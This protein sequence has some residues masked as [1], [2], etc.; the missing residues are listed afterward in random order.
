M[1]FVHITIDTEFSSAGFFNAP[2]TGEPVTE[3]A[4]R[5]TIDGRSEGLGFLLETFAEHRVRATFFVEVLHTLCFGEALMGGIAQEI[6]AAGHDVQIHL[7][8]CWLGCA[9]PGSPKSPLRPSQDNC[10][11]LLPE[12]TAQVIAYALAVFE[13]WGLPRPTAFRAGNLQASRATY[14]ALAQGGIPSS[15]NLGLGVWRPVEPELQLGSG[16]KSLAG[17]IEVPVTSY[18]VAWPGGRE[19]I[20]ALTITGSSAA[21]TRAVLRQASNAGIEDV[22]VLTHPFE[23]IKRGDP[24]YRRVARNRV[25]QRRLVELCR[26]LGD[27]ASGL[28]STTFRERLP[29]WQQAPAQPPATL[30]VPLGLAALRM[31]ENF[32]NDRIW[33]F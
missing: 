9:P 16:R 28:S 1:T 24:Q 18:S 32:L 19:Q 25:N 6:H 31:G 22:V 20:K 4:V 33:A 27:P 10:G 14:D 23:F 2:P 5:C 7:H 15:S 12:Q 8:P 17:V 29:A 21:E 3:Q 26:L 30:G 13:R 11:R